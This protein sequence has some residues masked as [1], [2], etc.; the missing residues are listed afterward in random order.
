[1]CGGVPWRRVALRRQ[2]WGT[3]GLERD[4]GARRASSVQVCPSDEWLCT[5]RTGPVDVLLQL[6]H[7][8]APES[9]RCV[10][11][12]REACVLDR[13]ADRRPVEDRQGHGPQHARTSYDRGQVV[14]GPGGGGGGGR[15]NP[16]PRA[17][18]PARGA[19]AQVTPGGALGRSTPRRLMPGDR[20][21]GSRMRVLE[22]DDLPTDGGRAAV[23]GTRSPR[24]GCPPS[25]RRR[26]GRRD[27]NAPRR[28]RRPPA[29]P[30]H[31]P[32]PGR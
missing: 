2:P 32:S 24:R 9:H 28:M 8:D 20:S 25:G 14:R 22:P 19:G 17:G 11:G 29:T 3:A 12:A 21:P 18:P 23:R 30:L 31:R 27:Q 7:D 4:A 6:F 5:R 15:P 26:P 16:P 13:M 1:M 10:R